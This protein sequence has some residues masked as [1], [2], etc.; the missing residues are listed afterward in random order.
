LPRSSW[1]HSALKVHAFPPSAMAKNVP[2]ARARARP[3]RYHHGRTTAVTTSSMSAVASAT[4]DVQSSTFRTFEAPEAVRKLELR[5]AFFR[6]N[7]GFKI[8][9]RFS[10]H[11][12]RGA[13]LRQAAP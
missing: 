9:H 13:G 10:S 5:A 3:V 6:G 2:P 7:H 1:P 12:G 11:F 8:S 4:S